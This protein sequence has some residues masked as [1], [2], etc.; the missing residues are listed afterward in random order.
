M[1][2]G[3]LTPTDSFIAKSPRA[4]YPQHATTANGQKLVAH[5]RWP[6]A[7]AASQ[8]AVKTTQKQNLRKHSAAKNEQTSYAEMQREKRECAA[9]PAAATRT[10]TR[11]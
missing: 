4:S 11:T 3:Y 9:R 10:R 1:S 2:M 6:A 8:P 7:S 5:D